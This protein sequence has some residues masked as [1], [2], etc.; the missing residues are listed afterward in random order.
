MNRFFDAK[1]LLIVV[2]LLAALLAGAYFLTNGANHGDSITSARLLA[3]AG[4][5]S[6]RG[7]GLGPGEL[8]PDFEISTSEGKHLRLSELRGRPVLI[9]FWATWC[10]SCLTEMPEIKA[11]Q[12]EKGL[13]A[14]NVLAINAGEPLTSARKFIDFLQAPFVYGLDPGLVVSDAYGVYGLPVSVF[15]DSEGVVQ[16]TYNGH[17]SRQRL[18]AYVRAAIEAT[19]P[20]GFPETLRLVS[21]VP[22]ERVL[23]VTKRE[24]GRVELSSR[25][26]RCDA[27]YCAEEALAA[28][29]TERGIV[30]LRLDSAPAQPVL[31]LRYDAAVLAE[32]DVIDAVVKALEAYDDP[33]YHGALEVR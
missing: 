26:L 20:G 22:R 12:E 3:T 16:T 14:F 10:G 9:N 28:L 15:I 6:G 5:D 30:S 29:K 21:T 32:R 31:S 24:K 4:K 18:E 7:V 8:A 13:D 1:R 11:L 2:P 27:R 17:A 19:P 33:L 25:S 23:T